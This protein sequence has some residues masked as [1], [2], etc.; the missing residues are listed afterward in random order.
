MVSPLPWPRSPRSWLSRLVVLPKSAPRTLQAEREPLMVADTR[1][2]DYSGSEYPTQF[3]SHA[4]LSNAISPMFPVVHQWMNGSTTWLVVRIEE[5][6]RGAA[7]ILDSLHDAW[8]DLDGQ[9]IIYGECSA[10]V[11][12]PGDTGYLVFADQPNVASLYSMSS[13]F[14]RTSVAFTICLRYFDLDGTRIW[15]S[16]VECEAPATIR[17]IENEELTTPSHWWQLQRKATPD[18]GKPH[19]PPLPK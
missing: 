3:Q 6:G 18:L 14:T 17:R 9:G 8:I 7:L 10:P 16:V 13:W 15:K 5:R 11:F 12:A 1:D 19:P 4:L 2:I